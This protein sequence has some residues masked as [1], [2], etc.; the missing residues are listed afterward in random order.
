MNVLHVLAAV[1]VVIFVIVRQLSGEPLRAKRLI[2]LPAILAVI[3]FT[4]LGKSGRHLTTTDLACLVISAVIAAGIGGAQ[5][6]LIRLRPRDGV[7][8]AR[9]PVR[10]LWLWLALVASRVVMTFVATALHAHVAGSSAPILLLLGV[11]RLGQA[12]VVTPRALASGVPFAPE[13][14]GRSFDVRGALADRF[15]RD[16]AAP[17]TTGAHRPAYPRTTRPCTRSERDIPHDRDRHRDR[18]RRRIRR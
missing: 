12:A 8:W 16:A 13:R 18:A 1:G 5:G 2:L 4:S 6:A 9:M 10:G 17:P 14:D 7:L 11:N 15:D 3:G